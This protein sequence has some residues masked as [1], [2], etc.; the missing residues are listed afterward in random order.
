MRKELKKLFICIMSMVLSFQLVGSA[1]NVKKIYALDSV[2]ILGENVT[3]Y[4]EETP[5]KITYTAVMESGQEYIS[6]Y[7][8]TTKKIYIN[9]QEMEYSF[10]GGR[11]TIEQNIAVEKTNSIYSTTN[12]WTPVTV[13]EDYYI[14][15]SP[16][17]DFTVSAAAFVTNLY[18][19]ITAVSDA[20]L[21]KKL[22][23]SALKRTMTVIG[24]RSFEKVM[25][26]LDI[27]PSDIITATLYYDL[28]RTSG[29][30]DLMG[31]GVK[32]TAYRYANYVGRLWAGGTT[33]LFSYNTG[34]YGSWWS[35]SKPYSFDIPIEDI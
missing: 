25:G 9:G 35:S 30:V 32:V 18:L 17:I 16:G 33:N 20:A 13:I 21:K 1:F 28:Q 23:E 5:F 14:D 24:E 34:E 4:A 26:W 7:N 29:L 2:E 31:S 3:F 15:F 27:H 8:K 11:K 19:G 12:P 10:G 22:T 6:E